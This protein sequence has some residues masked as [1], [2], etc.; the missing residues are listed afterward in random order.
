MGKKRRSKRKGKSRKQSR[1]KAK[2]RRYISKIR[3]DGKITKKEGRKAAKRGISLRK[4]R[5]R[6]ISAH[7]ASQRNYQRNVKPA[8]RNS[9]GQRRPSYEPLK[10]KRGAEQADRRRQERR[11]SRSEPRRRRRREPSRPDPVLTTQPVG[12][13]T[14]V[15]LPPPIA[16]PIEPEYEYE[17][18]DVSG[19][20]DE[21]N[22][23]RDEMAEGMRMP[24]DPRNRQY[25]LGIRTKRGK[26]NRQ[27]ARGT[28]GRRSKRVQGLQSTS[29][30]L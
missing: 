28:F 27:G 20:A 15:D 29:I 22:S 25:V 10:I 23:I 12:D 8:S 5:N 2:R 14:P 16:P 17:M 11:R 26:R 21:L 4:I 9:F 3:R 1:S 24:E 13:F 6:H 30:N 18:P 19:Y 7:R